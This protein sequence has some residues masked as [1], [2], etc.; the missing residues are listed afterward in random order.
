MI[1][2]LKIAR[3]P[4]VNAGESAQVAP[5]TI[6]DT[7]D[8]ELLARGEVHQEG[9]GQGAH[10][11]GEARGDSPVGRGDAVVGRDGPR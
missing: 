1:H 6:R 9:A 2:T 5:P 10:H 11:H 8:D 3:W 7:R 4:G